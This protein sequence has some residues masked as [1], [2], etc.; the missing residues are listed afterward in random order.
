MKKEKKMQRRV[1]KRGKG[2][3]IQTPEEEQY[4]T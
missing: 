1:G 4:D 3:K 2:S